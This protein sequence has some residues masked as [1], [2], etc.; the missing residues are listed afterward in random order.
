MRCLMTILFAFFMA[1]IAYAQPADKVLA[2][3]KYNFSH[4]RDTNSRNNPYTETMILMIGKNASA[5]TSLD[6]L[7]R[8]LDLPKAPSAPFK[9]VNLLDQYFFAKENK[10][11]TRH[12]FS[13]AY[14]LIEEPQEKIKWTLKKDTLNINGISCKQATTSFK[15]RKWT[16]W[17]APDLPFQSGPW[18]LNSL[19]GLIIQAQDEQKEVIFEFAGIDDLKSENLDN[20]QLALEKAY[21]KTFFFKPEIT[22]QTDAKKTTR[23]EFDKVYQIYLKDPIGFAAA[24]TGTPRNRIFMGRSTTGVSHDITNNP[25]EL[26]EKNNR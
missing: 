4:V 25:I 13:D 11:I 16:A 6:R 17:Y 14:Y 20:E 19:P 5:Y 21:Q 15:G 18:K 23:A 24:Q 1:I 10:L 3:V 2:R 22:L 9:P 26:Q 8:E 12:R 7:E